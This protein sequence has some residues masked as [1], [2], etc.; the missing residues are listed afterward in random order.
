MRCSAPPFP[1][2]NV[3]APPAP[4]RRHGRCFRTRRLRR[5]ALLGL[6]AAFVGAAVG[7]SSSSADGTAIELPNGEPGIGFDDLRYSSALHRVLVP[8]GRSGAL[9]LIEPETGNARAIE[10]FSSTPDFGG[11][12]DDG[13]TSVDEG[14]GYLFVTDRSSLSLHVVDPN[15]GAIVVTAPL[16]AGPDYVRYVAATDEV[17]VTEPSGDQLEIFSLAKEGLPTPT[18]VAVIPVDNGPESLVI[19]GTRGRAYTHRWQAST[20]AIDLASR[21]VVAEWPNGCSASRGI[22]L[23]EAR[24]FL[25]A[26]CREGTA[27]VLDAAGDGRVVSALARGAGY[28]VMGY[29]PALGHLYLAGGD[30]ACLTVLGLSASGELSYLGRFD[31]PG[32]TNGV[33]ADDVGN[34]WVSEPGEG[35]MRRVRDPY[36]ASLP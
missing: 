26:A 17:W 18:S 22:G 13:P 16:A 29:N 2:S 30:C 32:D 5:A 19:D 34:A 31:A 11:G 24:G 33:V 6:A 7:C 21:A 14:R 9:F 25:F 8:G 20:I 35:R 36:A 4:A 15:Q 27:T 10:G 28:D 3:P 23:D 1:N 12:H